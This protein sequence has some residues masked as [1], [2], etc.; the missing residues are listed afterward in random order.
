MMI[1][2]GFYSQFAKSMF[3][4]LFW[5]R[6]SVPKTCRRATHGSHLESILESSSDPVVPR[7]SQILLDIFLTAPEKSPM[8]KRCWDAGEKQICKN[9][10]WFHSLFHDNPEVKTRPDTLVKLKISSMT[11]PKISFPLRFCCFLNLDGMLVRL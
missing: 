7:V 10:F 1:A 8:G 11:A 9:R 4:I 3:F 2:L 5:T 6:N